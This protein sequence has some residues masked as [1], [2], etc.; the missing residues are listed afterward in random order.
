[1]GSFV[2]QT[3]GVPATAS[4]RLMDKEHVKEGDESLRKMRVGL[5]GDVQGRG[6]DA[7]EA[8]GAW[9]II[10]AKEQARE[11]AIAE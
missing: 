1:L 5:F 10:P 7:A 4:D 3:G 11:K 8:L 6:I 9:L 2:V